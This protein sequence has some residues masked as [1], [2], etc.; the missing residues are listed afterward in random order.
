MAFIREF[1][2]IGVCLFLLQAPENVLRRYKTP[3]DIQF[4]PLPEG[5]VILEAQKGPAHPPRAV[6]EAVTGQESQA[7]KAGCLPRPPGRP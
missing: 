5:A 7:P 6:G 4:D 2:D 1:R 3:K